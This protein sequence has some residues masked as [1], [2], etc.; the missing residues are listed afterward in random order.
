[1]GQ[2]VDRTERF[3]K[4]KA[5]LLD[6]RPVHVDRFLAALE[7]SKAT[8]RRDLEYLRDRLYWPIVWDRD[9]GGYRID[10]SGTGRYEL[11]GLWLSS[12]EAHALLTM[13]HLLGN[14]QPG[15]LKSHI[16]P[17]KARIEALLETPEQSAR[18]I[19]KRIRVLP[20]AA[21]RIESASFQLLAHAL[22]I[23]R[24]IGITH[25]SRERNQETTRE[26][27][28]QR[29]VHYR[30]NWYLDAW[31]HGKEGLRTFSV[32]TIRRA[33]LAEKKAR[34]V[35]DRVLDEELSAGYGI[36]AGKETR[37]ARLR[38]TPQR[39]RWVQSEIWH[40]RQKA[41]LDGERYVLEVP[42]SDDRELLQDILRYGADV[43]V[44]APRSLRQ[45]VRQRLRA[46]AVQY[47]QN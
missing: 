17:L 23:R 4:I 43:E 2:P 9:R 13:H 31:D 30:D 16:E 15:F 32:E 39:A 42:Y 18:E 38:F 36:F 21:R 34:D 44:L 33:V 24:R 28:P 46:A 3:Y 47:E 25:F 22:L 19:M 11:P 37:T 41:W 1:M 6:G 10:E 26:V 29:L 20:M 45:K 7:V 8:F 27:S 14:L 12:A 35:P 40:S 5:M